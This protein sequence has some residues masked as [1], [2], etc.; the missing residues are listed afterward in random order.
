MA[1]GR[2]DSMTLAGFPMEDIVDA[3]R[4]EPAAAW[5]LAQALWISQ[6]VLEV[7]WPQEKIA[8]LAE[9]LESKPA[10]EGGSPRG[11]AESGT[12]K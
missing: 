7:F 11:D 4:S 8:I 1:A 9:L 12:R 3:V 10:S 5:F 2:K 6:P